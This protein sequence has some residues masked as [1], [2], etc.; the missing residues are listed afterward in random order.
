MM[1][2][3]SRTEQAEI[4]LRSAGR[5]SGTTRSRTQQSAA[6]NG[7]LTIFIPDY[8]QCI[9]KPDLFLQREVFRL[10]FGL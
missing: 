9:F 6:Y 8:I 5:F 2:E 4:E 1:A 10:F 7:F 3:Q